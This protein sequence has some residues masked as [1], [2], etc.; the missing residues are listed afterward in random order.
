[1]DLFL[2]YLPAILLAYGILVMGGASP[3]PAVA[4]LMGISFGQGRHA[5]L[6][7]CVGIACGSATVNTLTLMGVGM[8]LSQ[9]AWAMLALKLIGS[10]Y[11]AYLAY[12]AF[13]KA[14]RPPQITIE[15]RQTLSTTQLFVMGFA[16]QVTNPKAIAFWLAIAAL[17][18]T[19]GAPFW[20][21]GIY[22]LGAMIVSFLTHGTWALLLSAAPIRAG[23][24]KVRRWIEGALGLFFAFAAFK[25]A[26]SRT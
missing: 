23:Y 20:I 5:A 19:A 18:P 17:T 7:A 22:V 21:V 26:T 14:V 11:L 3:G 15:H 10:G 24:Q 4:M 9:V 12:G 6:T 8:L 2:T 13:R 25:L 16:L 1:M